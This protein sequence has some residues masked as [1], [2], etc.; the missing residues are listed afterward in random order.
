MA[1]PP[2]TMPLDNVSIHF[3][4]SVPAELQFRKADKEIIK[5]IWTSPFCVLALP[6]H[7]GSATAFVRFA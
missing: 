6:K 1:H 3:K 2:T 5:S 7:E 4:G